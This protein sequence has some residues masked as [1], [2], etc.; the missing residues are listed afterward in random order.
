ME[1]QKLEVAP[2][3]EFSDDYGISSDISFE[4]QEV[5]VSN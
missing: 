4:T 5:A 2:S 1:N 3:S